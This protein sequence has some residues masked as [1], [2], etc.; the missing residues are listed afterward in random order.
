MASK[1]PQPS[2]INN[3][4][5]EVKSRMIK[6]YTLIFEAEYDSLYLITFQNVKDE[7]TAKDILNESLLAVLE[8][9]HKLDQKEFINN[10]I[11]KI[12]ESSEKYRNEI[13]EKKEFHFQ[14][15]H[16]VHSDESSWDEAVIKAA[17]DAFNKLPQKQKRLLGETLQ[18]TPRK[19][20]ENNK[21]KTGELLKFNWK[22][23]QKLKKMLFGK[24]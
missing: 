13:D 18:S 6:I 16:T 2:D 23:R 15:Y 24:I 7:E 21:M 3:L 17:V 9:I 8:S 12:N 19:V 4:I 10:V 20:A 14:H 1:F 22:T 5:D 11:V